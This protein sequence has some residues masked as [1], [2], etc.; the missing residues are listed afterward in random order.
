[1]KIWTTTSLGSDAGSSGYIKTTG[2]LSGRLKMQATVSTFHRLL[3]Y[4]Q[5]ST[6]MQGN[7]EP[8]AQ[9]MSLI[10]GHVRHLDLRN[11]AAG[12]ISSTVRLQG[13][14]TEAM[15]S[16]P[17]P[18]PGRPQIPAA[19]TPLR[20]PPRDSSYHVVG[21][22]QDRQHTKTYRDVF[23]YNILSPSY[24]S[25][26]VQCTKIA[27][28][29]DTSSCRGSLPS[30]ASPVSLRVPIFAWESTARSLTPALPSSVASCALVAGRPISDCP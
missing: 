28:P 27:Q 8:F 7:S 14:V 15:T 6:R 1:M 21:R 17:S 16:A 19:E 10:G 22:V 20:R 25:Y 9:G 18:A 29:S 24:P 3:L 12:P 23:L 26:K 30:Y 5:D 2:E 11:Q 13:K 4:Y